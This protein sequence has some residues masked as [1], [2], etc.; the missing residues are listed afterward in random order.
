MEDQYEKLDTY[1]R[2]VKN[3]YFLFSSILKYRIIFFSLIERLKPMKSSVIAGCI[4]NWV[5]IGTRNYPVPSSHS[6][7]KPIE[8]LCVNFVNNNV[9]GINQRISMYTLYRDRVNCKNEMEVAKFWIYFFD[10]FP[11]VNFWICNPNFEP[12]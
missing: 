6:Y 2:L 4:T 12:K 8:K 1:N 11:S 3:L 10:M 5:G 9:G 7:G